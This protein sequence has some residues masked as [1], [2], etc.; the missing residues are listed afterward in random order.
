MTALK[1]SV[2]A[3]QQ[4]MVPLTESLYVSGHVHKKDAVL[5]E[6]G[7]GY[8]AEVCEPYRVGTT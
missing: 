3:G 5:V 4:M 7:A 2:G 8:Y 1:L 6:I